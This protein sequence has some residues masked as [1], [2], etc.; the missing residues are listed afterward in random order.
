MN[1]TIGV[2]V[3]ETLEDL[4]QDGG[5]RSLVENA[6][7]RVHG[8]HSELEYVEKRAAIE[9][10]EHEPELFAHHKRRVVR[11]H[12]LMVALTH[13]L[14]LFEQLL[15]ARIALLQI[16]PLYRHSFVVV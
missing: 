16:D 11:D 10:L 14:D 6:M 1:V 5:N 2:K 8:L 9:E 15:H 7:S 3:L 12:V 13:H 4:S